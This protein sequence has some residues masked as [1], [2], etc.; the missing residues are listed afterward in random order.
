MNAEQTMA[1]VRRSVTVNAPIERAFAVFTES[2]GTWWPADYHVNPNGYETAF[3]EPVV[4]GRW[5][6]RAPDGSEYDWGRVLAWDP[7]R[8]VVL[9]WQLNN[10][11]VFEPDRSSEV[12]ITF[13][14]EEVGR[15]RV[16]LVHSK[17]EG[18]TGGDSVAAVVG[19]ETGWGRL[20]P[21]FRAAAEAA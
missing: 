8:R 13:T 3:I 2:F 21:L 9:T 5:F 12:E 16:D 19:G 17:F 1:A 4:G 7:P 11:Y 20:L 10:E 14:S 6:E 15:T 18:L